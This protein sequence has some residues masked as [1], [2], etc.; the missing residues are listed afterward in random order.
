MPKRPLPPDVPEIGYVIIQLGLTDGGIISSFD[1]D[2]MEAEAALGYL[3]SFADMIR[4]DLRDQ[5]NPVEQL[6]DDD[7]G[8]PE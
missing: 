3:I 8:E 4:D 2:G 7:E 6:E 1:F 5:W